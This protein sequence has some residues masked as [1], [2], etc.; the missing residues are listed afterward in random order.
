M[1]QYLDLLRNIKENGHN[2][3]SRNGIRRSIFGIHLRFDLSK[4]ELPLVTTREIPTDKFIKELLWFI[5]GD[6]NNSTLKEQDTNIWNLWELKEQDIEDFFEKYLREELRNQLIAKSEANRQSIDIGELTLEISK[7]KE[8]FIKNVKDTKLN[9]IGP[10]YGFMW[11]NSPGT[12]GNPFKLHRQYEDIPSDKL[13]F[14]QREYLKTQD[15]NSLLGADPKF[16]DF[17]LM[18]YYSTIDQLNELVINLKKDPFSSRNIVTALVPQFFS[19]PGF[20]P[21]ENIMLNKGCLYPCH[22]LFQCFAHPPK[23]EGGKLRLSLRMSQRSTDT[24]IGA[25]SNIAQ[26]ALLTHML[27]HVTDMEPYEFIWESGDTHIY[28]NQLDLI[29]EQLEREPFPLPKVW[30]N[31]EVKDLFQFTI[32]DIKILD[33]QSHPPMKYPISM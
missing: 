6:T 23:E 30:L 27:A 11:R 28:G 5:S 1:K 25:V 15:P 2:H 22:M 10:M 32:D 8:M 20:S 16:R 9:A 18:Q 29:D 21:Q 7:Q 12:L 24:P 17:A 4:G 19:I 33:Y 3:E 26:Y 13:E 14:Y 31:P